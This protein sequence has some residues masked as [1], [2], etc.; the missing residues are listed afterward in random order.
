MGVGPSKEKF[1][2]LVKSCS[3]FNDE[4]NNFKLEF[5]IDQEN[6][7]CGGDEESLDVDDFGEMQNQN[8][9][10][11]YRNI[12]DVRRFP[13]IAVGTLTLKFPN[14]DTLY[15]HTCFLIHKK[16]IVTLYSFLRRN[17]KSAIEATTTFTEEK[18]NLKRVRKNEKKDLAVF[19]LNEASCTQWIGVDEYDKKNLRV[20][21]HIKAIYADGKGTK[22]DLDRTESI[23]FMEE[24][25]S[26]GGRILPFLKEIN[27]D[28]DQIDKYIGD[29]GELR[30]K[31]IGGV[32]Y[33]KNRQNGGAYAL[34]IIDKNLQAQFFDKETVKYLYEQ[35]Y[36][37]KLSHKGG[38][39][40]TNIVEI[41]L[42]KKNLGPPQI[43]Y[44]CE[45]N[46]SNLKKLN[47]LKNQIGPQGAFY[48]GQSKFSNLEILILN[49]NEI[50]DEGMQ[51]LSKG[52]FLGLKYLYL[53]HNNISNEG[54]GFLF[55]SIFIDTLLLLDLSDNQNIN[56]DGINIIK[57]KTQDN[58]SVLK[59]LLCLNLSATN[60]N[61]T[62]L[63]YL[64]QITFPKLKKLII[65]DIDFSKSLKIVDLL[66]KNYEVK[67][68]GI[69]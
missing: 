20:Y 59:E 27:C 1:L 34:G 46:L 40:E 48:L 51:Y 10:S 49:F 32:I 12:K 53:F 7:I 26:L 31:I 19:F 64:N 6:E 69:I 9:S 58:N 28:L 18:L 60:I 35:V 8:S 23:A 36:T 3:K 67:M 4:Q 25:N 61:D 56:A 52:P 45:F 16:V 63:E 37:A 22:A 39:D 30:N 14:S 21:G 24:R 29:K 55:D 68:D 57:N 15:E 41:D 54:V 5:Q 33:Y 13:Y 17:N 66:N 50:G 2:E 62:A 44:L 42:A 38:I 43:K 47:L 65:Q 11:I